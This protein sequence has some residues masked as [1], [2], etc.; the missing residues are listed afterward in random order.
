MSYIPTGY[1]YTPTTSVPA[2]KTDPYNTPGTIEYMRR[3][4]TSTGLSTVPKTAST[5]GGFGAGLLDG[6]KSVW[7]D[8]LAPAAKDRLARAGG[9]GDYG[10]G[11][12]PGGS[13]TPSW[14]V[15]AAVGL[16]ALGLFMVMKKRK[17]RR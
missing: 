4:Q 16:G 15:P 9:G 11:Y 12:A 17:G 8:V 1:L 14:L 6:L 2:P 5:G 10:G 3:M 13:S 7:T